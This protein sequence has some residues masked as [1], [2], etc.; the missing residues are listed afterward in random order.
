M[1][2]H[3]SLESTIK[4]EEVS[5]VGKAMA[6][7]LA[8]SLIIGGLNHMSNSDIISTRSNHDAT[9]NIERV[10]SGMEAH[11]TKNK[12]IPTQNL[13]GHVMSGLNSTYLGHSGALGPTITIDFENTLQRMWEHKKGI[14]INKNAIQHIIDNQVQTYDQDLA[15]KPTIHQAIEYKNHIIQDV[16]N[17]LDF[18]RFASAH[19]LN[20]TQKTFVETIANNVNGKHL[21]A[22]SMSEL[23]PSTNGPLN[24]TLYDFLLQNV[25]IEGVALIPAQGDNK[26][27][28]GPYQLTSYIVSEASDKR[29]EANQFFDFVQDQT[30]PG[31][32]IYLQPQDHVKAAYGNLVMQSTRTVRNMSGRN[33]RNLMSRDSDEILS[34]LG[35]LH[36]NPVRTRRIVTND[37]HNNKRLISSGFSAN[38]ARKTARNY[39]GINNM[40]SIKPRRIVNATRIPS[41]NRN[42]EEYSNWNT[43]KLEKAINPSVARSKIEPL[44]Q[45][46]CVRGIGNLNIRNEDGGV[47]SQD[48]GSQYVIIEPSCTLRIQ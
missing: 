18:D 6:Y 37:L 48:D 15:H 30:I 34:L 43:Y 28:F 8:G 3:K 16:R 42:W 13:E 5:F 2:E 12:Q 35:A 21:T 25:G 47:W 9:T 32:M 39:N 11:P 36:Y 27:S 23:L 20:E 22:I 10:F 40:S 38:Y 1:S 46:N 44:L 31:S 7:L 24:A 41:F 33:L 26:V 17:H 45:G 4:Q 14:S 19:N 29:G